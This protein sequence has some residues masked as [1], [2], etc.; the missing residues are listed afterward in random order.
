MA[1]SSGIF[2]YSAGFPVANLE[3]I[4]F[5]PT[6]LDCTYPILSGP[7]IPVTSLYN[8]DVNLPIEERLHEFQGVLE[9]FLHKP[10]DAIPQQLFYTNAAA[11]IARPDG[12]KG[13][14]SAIFVVVQWASDLATG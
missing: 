12:G 4:I 9:K 14:I 13:N 6:R 3:M 1:A 2:I 7:V 10:A 11:G 5:S 8:L